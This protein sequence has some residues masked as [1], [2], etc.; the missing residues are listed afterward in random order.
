MVWRGDAGDLG[1]SLG[2]FARRYPRARLEY[3][4]GLREFEREA[5]RHA[6]R[7]ELR[8]ADGHSVPDGV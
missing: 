7:M 8:R 6:T 5:Q 3:E 1:L 2:E 4:R